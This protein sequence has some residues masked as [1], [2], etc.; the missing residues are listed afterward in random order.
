MNRKTLWITQ[1]ALLLALLVSVQMI[2]SSMKNTLITGSLVN[3]ILIIAVMLGGLSSG[4]TVACLSPIF[5]F[6]FGIGP[7]FWQIIICIALGNAV[8]VV[9]W[10]FI[11]GRN[12]K[13]SVASTITATIVGGVAKFIFLYLSVVQFLLPF[14][15]HLQGPQAKMI[16]ATFSVPQLITAL[17]GGG[18]AVVVLPLLTKALGSKMRL[19]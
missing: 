7:A 16:S 18:I 2:T 8:L 3:L 19:N 9:A 13:M 4:L 11:A 14:V 1:T 15:L 17:I 5:A 12:S 6:F 10:H